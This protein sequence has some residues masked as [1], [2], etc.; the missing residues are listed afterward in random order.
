MNIFQCNEN[1]GTYSYK[2]LTCRERQKKQNHSGTEEFKTAPWWMSSRAEGKQEGG[3]GFENLLEKRRKSFFS[4]DLILY[5][6]LV[7]C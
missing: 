4:M 2:E 3:K 1:C 5:F 7:I 6:A